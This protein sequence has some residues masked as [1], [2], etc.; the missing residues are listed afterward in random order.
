MQKE[1]EP[2]YMKMYAGFPKYEH[3]TLINQHNVYY[4][5]KNSKER[6]FYFEKEH[7]D[8]IC[9]AMLYMQI[10]ATVVYD[11]DKYYLHMSPLKETPVVTVGP[12]GPSGKFW[13]KQNAWEKKNKLV[14]SEK[15]RKY[16]Y[17]QEQ[18]DDDA[19]LAKIGQQIDE[20]HEYPSRYN[21]NDNCDD[22][23]EHR[24][25]KYYDPD[26][27]DDIVSKPGYHFDDSKP[28]LYN[29]DDFADIADYA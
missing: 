29:D 23:F 24:T 6:Q 18:D 1:F 2:L 26:E 21:I 11:D 10:P 5:A 12:T 28:G 8:G 13:A 7:L 14:W 15:K 9:N 16:V 3:T 27:F 4:L 17:E 25:T 22:I 20:I 19:S